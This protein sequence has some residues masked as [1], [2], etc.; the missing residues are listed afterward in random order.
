MKSFI[1]SKKEIGIYFETDKE[2]LNLKKDS[3]FNKIE[4]LGDGLKQLYFRLSYDF[5]LNEKILVNFDF[6]KIKSNMVDIKL[7]NN[8]LENLIDNKKIIFD[9]GI[10]EEKVVLFPVDYF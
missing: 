3:Y 8:S 2:I 7:G 10:D 1:N 9:K 5:N 4:N 6:F